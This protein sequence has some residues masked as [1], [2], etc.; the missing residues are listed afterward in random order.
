[1][2]LTK[3]TLTQRLSKLKNDFFVNGYTKEALQLT[4][5]RDR[6]AD[7]IHKEKKGTKK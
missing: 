7:E 5:I 6:L 3:L 1:M 2:T 4:K